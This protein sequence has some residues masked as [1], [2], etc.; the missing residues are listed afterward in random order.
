VD[1]ELSC[2]CGAGPY[3]FLTQAHASFGA[4]Y[5]T[6]YGTAPQR[7]IQDLLIFFRPH[8]TRRYRPRRCIYWASTHRS[9]TKHRERVVL[10]G[11]INI[12]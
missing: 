7:Y 1:R 3:I 8:G 11:R 5:D 2:N 12:I 10:L 4:G 6:F 9:S